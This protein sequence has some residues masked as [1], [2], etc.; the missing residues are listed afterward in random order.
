MYVPKVNFSGATTVSGNGKMKLISPFWFESNDKITRDSGNYI[1]WDSTISGHFDGIVL[2]TSANNSAINT[3]DNLAML[4]FKTE[5]GNGFDTK[6]ALERLYDKGIV[7][8]KFKENGRMY[9]VVMVALPKPVCNTFFGKLIPTCNFS[10]IKPVPIL[11]TIKKHGVSNS[12]HSI[13]NISPIKIFNTSNKAERIKITPLSYKKA[14]K[15]LINIENLLK[16]L[17]VRAHSI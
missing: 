4:S 14:R 6:I 3:P 12:I 2:R 1:S 8:Y 16:K 17:Q 13:S 7:R 10:D 15:Q 9:T 11:K 5:A